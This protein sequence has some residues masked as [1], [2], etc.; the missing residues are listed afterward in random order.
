MAIIT[1]IICTLSSI[2]SQNIH[3][4]DDTPQKQQ[5]QQQQQQQN[6]HIYVR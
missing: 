3:Q 2:Y 5:Q 6:V 4:G 1:T